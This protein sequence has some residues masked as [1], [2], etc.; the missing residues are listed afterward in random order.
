[1]GEQNVQRDHDTLGHQACM[2][3]LLSE[4]RALDQ[5]LLDA[6]LTDGK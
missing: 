3:A 1:M 5:M 6:C 4:C 2:K